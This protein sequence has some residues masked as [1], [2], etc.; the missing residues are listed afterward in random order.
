M[1][2]KLRKKLLELARRDAVVR[3][4]L[5]ANGSLF[6]G[7]HPEMQAV[8]EENAAALERVLETAGWPGTSQIGKDGA[9][10]AWII[11]QHAI[12]LP[13]FQRRCLALLEDAAARGEAP[14]WQPAHLAD[15]IRSFEGRPQIYGTQFD[16]DDQGLMSPLPIEDPDGVDARRAALGLPPLAETTR[17]H[18]LQSEREPRPPDL[19]AR[20]REAREWAV[21]VG[22][23]PA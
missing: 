17:N 1:D 21:K 7:Y 11:A 20:R 14:A 13:A 2:K 15:R 6:D 4:R 3:D 8:H 10:A 9:D 19:E 18:R 16:W 23:R 12:G 22:W 5:A